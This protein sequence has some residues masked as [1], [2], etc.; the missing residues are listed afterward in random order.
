MLARLHGQG[1]S[2]PDWKWAETLLPNQ[3]SAFALHLDKTLGTG[4]G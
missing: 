4:E 2:K 3:V 1:E